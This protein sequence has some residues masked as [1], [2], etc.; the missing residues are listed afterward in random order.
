VEVFKM[1]AVLRRF[2][3]DER[4]LEASEYALLLA[5]IAIAIVAAVGLLR[6]AIEG[7]FTEAATIIDANSN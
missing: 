2:F 5:L 1:K 4:G 3:K 6:T 7:K